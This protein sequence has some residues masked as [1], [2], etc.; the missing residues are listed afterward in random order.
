MVVQ[1][2]RRPGRAAATASPRP[3]GSSFEVSFPRV[4]FSGGRAGAAFNGRAG[5]RTETYIMRCAA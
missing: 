4:F 3:G 2:P 1:R 5:A